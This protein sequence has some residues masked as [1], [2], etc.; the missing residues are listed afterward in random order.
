MSPRRLALLGLA[1]LVLAAPL[2]AAGSQADPETGDDANDDVAVNGGANCPGVPPLNCIFLTDND[3]EWANSDIDWAWVND[4]AGNL[5]FTA[6]MKAGAAFYPG[7][8]FFGKMPAEMEPFTYTF[9]F[10][11]TVNGTPFAAIVT[12]GVDG[13]FTPGGVT[14]AFLVHDGN[15][16]T[17]TVPKS[18]VGAGSNGAVVGALVFTSHG[19]DDDGNT[20]DDQAPD[21]GLA[22]RDYTVANGTT[23]NATRA[24]NGG[25]ATA[26]P[27][28]SSALTGTSTTSRPPVSGTAERSFSV[29]MPPHR[30]ATD[31]GKDT[32][33]LPFAASLAILL[34]L[35]VALRRR[36]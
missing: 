7:A 33:A 6:Q 30:D 1:A 5:S 10:A 16:L 3:F 4:T 2:A 24:D 21:N 17:V 9:T 12:M 34:G 31:D 36:L 28:G 19:E 8:E 35:V 20:L 32:P 13:V 27:G 18:L 22:S 11:F 29:T 23:S 25:N 15:Q 26:G 14:G